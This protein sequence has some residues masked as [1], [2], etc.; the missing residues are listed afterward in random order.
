MSDRARTLLQLTGA[1][2]VSFSTGDSATGQGT[3]VSGGG[4]A[5]AIDRLGVGP[6]AGELAL[7]EEVVL[8]DE[9]V[10]LTL[11]REGPG[12]GRLRVSWTSGPSY[13]EAVPLPLP[14]TSPSFPPTAPVAAAP[15]SAPTGR[16]VSDPAAALAELELPLW[17]HDDGL[18]QDGPGPG[19]LRAFVPSTPTSRLGSASF[20]AAHGV[21]ATYVGGAMAGGISSEE[22]V[23]A[24]SRAGMLSCFGAGGLSLERVEQAV[25]R[26][27]TTLGSSPY[28]FNLL[29]NPVE[30]QVEEQTVDLYLQGG[31]RTISASAYMRLTPAVVRF[32]LAGIAAE[33]QGIRTPHRVMAKV[34]RPEVAEQFFRP[35]PEAILRE[36]VGRGVLTEAQAKLAAHVPVAEDV[37]VEGDSGGHTDH[38]PLVALLPVIRRQRD[39]IAAEQGYAARGIHLRVGAGGGLGDPSSVHAA[40]ALG[41]D[42]VMTGSINQSCVEA[43]T[44]DVVRDMLAQAGI[45]DCTTGPAPDMFELGAHVQVLGR[46]SMWAQRA[47]RLY[48]IYRSADGLDAIPATERERIES[49]IMRRPLAEVWA[50]TAAFWAGRDPRELARAQ[51]DEKHRMALTFRWY[52]GMSSRW[53]RTGDAERKRDYQI[54]CGPAMGLFNDWVRG[55]W[56]EPLPARGVVPVAHALLHGAAV[57][58]RLDALRG[59]GLAVPATLDP[60]APWR[61]TKP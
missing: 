20:L 36:L 22:L 49:Q 33:G 17:A 9:G 2:R 28:S 50:E 8:E 19:P 55:T 54:W 59:A 4:L 57:L 47:Q 1:R 31:V 5:S 42:Y 43:G 45:A 25:Q 44:S 15:A 7:G 27:R 56:L 41:A 51:K 13:E 46:G 23:I 61:G 11:R 6:L 40:Y 48:E 12:H 39:R 53:A 18:Y 60:P 37:T 35:A 52:L 26:C 21:Q 30:P 3:T 38:R 10:S 16:R 34:S 58:R 32:R 29:H 24:F 14:S